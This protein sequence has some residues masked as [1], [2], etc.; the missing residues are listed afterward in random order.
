MIRGGKSFY[1]AFAAA[2]AMARVPK[3]TKRPAGQILWYDEDEETNQRK[4]KS[5]GERKR[6][7]RDR[8]A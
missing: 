5:K 8:W 4:R 7:K 3:E 6:N 1:L 2:W